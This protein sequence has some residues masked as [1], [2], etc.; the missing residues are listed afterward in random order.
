MAV[1]EPQIGLVSLA[2][3][4]NKKFDIK[5]ILITLG[6]EGVLI[7]KQKDQKWENDMLPALNP[8][9]KDPAGGGDALLVLVSMSLASE[10]SIWEA[11]YLGSVGAAVQVGRLGNLPIQKIEIQSQLDRWR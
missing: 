6:Q 5:N 1:H 10:A 7:H 4:L 3:E 2:Q 9:A 11:C 8:L